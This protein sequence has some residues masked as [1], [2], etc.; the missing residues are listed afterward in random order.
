MTD[1]KQK[2]KW[3]ADFEKQGREAVRAMVSNGRGGP[4]QH[5]EEAVEWLREKEIE[6]GK[7]ASKAERRAQMIYVALALIV[8]IVL[9]LKLAAFGLL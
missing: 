7:R 4:R 8:L 5:Y 1:D 2:A 3:R 6:D 9:G